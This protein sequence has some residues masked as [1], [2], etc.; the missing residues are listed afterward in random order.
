MVSAL[1]IA[2]TGAAGMLGTALIDRL[3]KDYDTYATGRH[4]GYRREEI[5]FIRGVIVLSAF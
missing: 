3:A 1:K 4:I 2:V 5:H